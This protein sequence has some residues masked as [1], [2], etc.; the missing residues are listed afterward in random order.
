[1]GAFGGSLIFKSQMDMSKI[2][3]ILSGKS[4]KDP[5][6]EMG[7]NYLMSCIR[8]NSKN[9]APSDRIDLNALQKTFQ[10]A[11]DPAVEVTRKD[12]YYIARSPAFGIESIEEKAHRFSLSLDGDVFYATVYDDDLALIGIYNHG[13][14]VGRALICERNYLGLNDESCGTQALNAFLSAFTSTEADLK[15]LDCAFIRDMI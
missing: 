3:R 11:A 12:E 5:F 6:T 14:I 7:I 2:K 1:M 9:A 15:Q 8:E 10:T 4:A 13:S